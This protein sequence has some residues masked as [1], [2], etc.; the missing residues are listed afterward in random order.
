[1][2]I[3]LAKRMNRRSLGPCLALKPLIYERQPPMFALRCS[4][5]RLR[6]C[7]TGWVH[8]RWRERSVPAHVLTARVRQL[9]VS[10]RG[11]AASGTVLARTSAQV[12]FERIVRSA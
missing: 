1:M 4:T 11:Y 9:S 2:A 10:W 3:R 5:R 8:P 7:L 6:S 12:S